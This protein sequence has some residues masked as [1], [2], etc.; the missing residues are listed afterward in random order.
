MFTI[1]RGTFPRTAGNCQ[2]FLTQLCPF[3]TQNQPPAAERWYPHVGILDTL[4]AKIQM[5][6]QNQARAFEH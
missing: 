3:F 4:K 5:N 2:S 1:K 6:F